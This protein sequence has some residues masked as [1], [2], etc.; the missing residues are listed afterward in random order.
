MESF[1]TQVI[2]GFQKILDYKII[3]FRYLEVIYQSHFRCISLKN[4]YLQASFKVPP[5]PI[6]VQSVVT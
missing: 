4:I 2:Q 6:S 1:R 5:L 3:S